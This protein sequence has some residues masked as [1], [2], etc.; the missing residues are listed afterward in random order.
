MQDYSCLNIYRNYKN[1]N[2]TEK[3]KTWIAKI[4]LKKKCKM[5]KIRLLD[6]K[7]LSVIKDWYHWEHWHIDQR[8]RRESHKMDPHKYA[9]LTFD[10]DAQPTEER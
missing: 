5:G 4:I 10:E 2:Y 8:K 1:T 6:L 3:Q 7:I 9:Q